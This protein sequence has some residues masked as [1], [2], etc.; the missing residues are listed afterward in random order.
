MVG[1]IR[2]GDTAE[3]A[4]KAAQTGHLV[5]STLHTNSTSETLIRLQQMGVARWMISS[6]LTL[7]VAQ[8]TV[9]KLCPHCKQRLNDP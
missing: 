4:I 5:L 8:R 7:V 6:A 1:E 9:R 3:I 2:D